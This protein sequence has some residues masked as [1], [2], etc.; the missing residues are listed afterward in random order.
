MHNPKLVSTALLAHFKLSFEKC[1]NTKAKKTSMPHV[2]YLLAVGSLMFAM[3]STRPDI[4][5]TVGVVSQF[6]VN[7]GKEH[8]NVVKWI[9]VYLRGTSNAAIFHRSDDLQV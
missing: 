2:L 9:L 3:V 4:V 5:Q 1:P 6:M 7:L 8:L